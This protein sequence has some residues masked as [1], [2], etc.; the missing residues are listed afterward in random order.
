VLVTARKFRD[1]KAAPADKEI[2]DLS[3]VESATRQLQAPE[4]GGK[5]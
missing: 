1:L 4:M 2:K 3:P 5:E